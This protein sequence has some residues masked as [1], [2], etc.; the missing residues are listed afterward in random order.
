MIKKIYSCEEDI[1]IAIE[2]FL[3]AEETFPVLTNSS[4]EKCS[5]CEKEA[6]YVLSK[7]TLTEK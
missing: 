5:Y 6:L 7:T 4:G 1:D 2:D 3:V